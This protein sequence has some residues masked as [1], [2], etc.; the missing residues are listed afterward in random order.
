MLWIL[1]LVTISHNLFAGNNAENPRT[2][3][4]INEQWLFTYSNEEI[5]NSA[6]PES[7]WQQ[8]NL[9]H[10]W[11]IDDTPTDTSAYRRGLGWYEK[12]LTLPDH[13]KGKRIFLHF[14]GANQTAEVF[15]NGKRAGKHIGGYTAFTFDITELLQFNDNG[16]RNTIAVKVDNH[17]NQDIPPLSADFTFYGGIYRDVWLMAV[18]PLHIT[19]DDFGSKGI[20]ISTP[21]VSAEQAS[22]SI[23][24]KI[25]NFSGTDRNIVI[26]N[27]VYAP[28]GMEAARVETELEVKSGKQTEFNSNEISL[29]NP[30]LWSPDRPNLYSVKTEIYEAGK[31]IDRLISPLGF[32]FFRMDADKGFYLNGKPLKLIGTNRHQDYAGYGNAL[33]NRLHVKDLQ[34]IKDAGFNFLRLAHYPQDPTVLEAADRL[35]LIIWEEI[36]IVNYVTVSDAFRENSKRMMMEMIRQHYNYPSIVFWGYMNEVFLHDADGN[37]NKEMNFPKEYLKWTVQLA[38]ELDNLTH[39]EDPG[40]IT[41]MAGHHS[42][43]YD[44][45]KIS[46]I[47]DAMGFNLYQGWYSSRFEDF[48][49]FVDAMH[50][51]FPNRKIIISEYGAG[52]DERLHSL[53]PQRFDFTTEYQQAYHES[54]LKQILARPFIGASAVWCQSDFGSNRRGDSK[55]QI[56]QKGLQYFDRRP[57]DIYYFYQAAL[58]EK[59]VVH[60]ASHDWLIRNNTG[61]G[62]NKHPLKIYSNLSELDILIDGVHY[63]TLEVNVSHILKVDLML[64][65]GKHIIETKGKLKGVW[66][67]DRVEI[68]VVDAE[69][70]LNS[71]STEQMEFAVNVGSAAQF[72]DDTGLVWQ[73]DRQYN[74]NNWGYDK[75]DARPINGSKSVLGSKSDP[76]YQTYREGIYSYRF[77]VPRGNYEVEL[78]LAEFEHQKPAERVMDILINGQLVWED[79]DLVLEYGYLQAVKR[80][81]EIYAGNPQG[82]EIKFVAKKGKT[83]LNGICLRKK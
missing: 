8:I 11:N 42:H 81:F 26:V 36:P 47:P 4:S 35:G 46:E 83:I 52:S 40:R 21:Q 57:K 33:P 67:S 59:P 18:Y 48:G 31:L 49:E 74:K 28:S 14:E 6:I 61:S 22:V 3:F 79:I 71:P 51:E 65:S 73:E 37:R 2:S 43:L 53:N 58:N 41:V 16:N 12:E 78:C 68:F 70:I 29:D 9:P 25:D 56:N 80:R 72:I 20:Y 69:L 62:Q 23:R 19:L 60:I 27:S 63:K 44:K 38:Q 17:F 32:R 50:K 24:G 77:K 5:K 55:P 54:Y 10:T 66:Y 82:I 15:V 7:Q 30:L 13:L 75:G 76:L 39:Q 45:T 34:M 64:N 1:F